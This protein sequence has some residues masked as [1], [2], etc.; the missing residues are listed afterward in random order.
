MGYCK[1]SN[2]TLT[3][4]TT[5][6]RYLQT[7]LT[8]GSIWGFVTFKD[9]V[10]AYASGTSPKFSYSLDGENWV[11]LPAFLNSGASA[12]FNAALNYVI[13]DN[14]MIV[15]FANGFSSITRDGI[16]WE[17]QDRGLNS[18]SLTMSPSWSLDSKSLKR[19][20]EL[21]NGK[22]MA[23]GINGYSAITPPL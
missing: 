17:A 12:G 23:F 10:I 7:G 4:W 20:F 22:L 18:G 1:I 19:I 14:F 13:T 2:E 8:S 21:N 3:S 16:E 6:P 15:L 11:G 5:L 9:V